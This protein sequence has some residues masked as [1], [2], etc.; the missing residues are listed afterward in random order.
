MLLP[1][2]MP[3]IEDRQRI[4]GEIEPAGNSFLL[5]FGLLTQ[6]PNPQPNNQ[7]YQDLEEA[8]IYPTKQGEL[9]LTL[10]T[11]AAPFMKTLLD[12]LHADPTIN[13][14]IIPKNHHNATFWKTVSKFLRTNS[15]IES[16]ITEDGVDNDFQCVIEALSANPKSK[17]R[18]LI[19]L[20]S[21]TLTK[22][23]SV[24]IASTFS[25]RPIKCI[26]FYGGMQNNCFE[27]FVQE[28]NRY[29]FFESATR[30]EL[31]SISKGNPI[32]T[33]LKMKWLQ[34]IRI[35]ACQINVND[36]MHMASELKSLKSV[37]VTNLKSTD[38]IDSYEIPN[39]LE[40][41]S[42]TECKFSKNSLS[43]LWANIMKHHPTSNAFDFILNSIKA[44]FDDLFYVMNTAGFSPYL[45]SFTWKK[46]QTDSEFFKAISD[47]PNLEIVN[48]TQSLNTKALDACAN[49]IFRC[50]SL[51]RLIIDGRKKKALGNDIIPLFKLLGRGNTNFEYVSCQQQDLTDE[52]LPDIADFLFENKKI[53][54][55]NFENNNFSNVNSIKSFYEK[56][57][58]RGTPLS[59]PFPS[60]LIKKLQKKN[61]ISDD[62]ISYI[63]ECHNQM[64]AGTN[65]AVETIGLV[66]SRD[67]EYD[68]IS[69]SQD[70]IMDL[71]EEVVVQ[72]ATIVMPEGD[73]V[74]NL[75]D[76]SDWT[77]MT[78]PIPAPDNSQP[79]KEIA[80]SYS[81]EQIYSAFIAV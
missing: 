7:F 36:I 19:F 1:S 15:T 16:I 37:H 53:S 46:N 52:S 31:D 25:I 29:P 65:N 11:D 74:D 32:P 33:I 70:V 76:E 77:L 56:I 18:S 38:K 27:A 63:K 61:L 55:A 60:H 72:K 49:F 44:D 54:S 20:D 43:S 66:Q 75:K 78:V 21:S 35:L 68:R 73:P 4:C 9:D 67:D 8:Y 69:V 64:E 41:L 10:L 48:L 30:L 80:A 24:V 3:T 50:T 23:L 5:R 13:S 59:M 12:S 14:V 39:T 45:K 17:L 51:K 71:Q 79:L 2:E 81:F 62:D 47:F 22:D 6:K 57:M 58:H 28:A 42:I 40:Q 34:E 26:G